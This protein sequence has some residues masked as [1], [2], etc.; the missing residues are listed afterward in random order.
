MRKIRII[1]SVIS[2]V[3][4]LGFILFL[5]LSWKNIP[6][7]VATHFNAAGAYG[8]KKSLLMEP[9]LMVVFFLVLSLVE[10]FPSVWN[11]PVRLTSENRDRQLL[12]AALMLG[13]MKILVILL[14]AD[15]GMSSIFPGFPV[16]PLHLLLTLTGMTVIGGI[17]ASIKLR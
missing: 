16:W 6:E 14:L 4:I 1:T 10:H 13:I 3:L 8:S 5:A 12:I 7:T 17:I 15:A 2:A 11:M 9:V